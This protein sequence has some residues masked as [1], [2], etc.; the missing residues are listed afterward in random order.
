MM[1]TLNLCLVGVLMLT[2][3]LQAEEKWEEITLATDCEAYVEEV[4]PA[5]EKHAVVRE[6]LLRLCRETKLQLLAQHFDARW[7]WRVT[8]RNKVFWRFSWKVEM[9]NDL[10]EAI[11]LEI[12]GRL[13]DR[14]A[15]ALAKFSLGP[16]VL[17]PGEKAR[18]S[19]FLLLEQEKAETIR[20]ARAT[21]IWKVEGVEIFREK[22]RIPISP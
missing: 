7:S 17:E 20:G 10:P 14:E 5:K 12:D 15:Y 21:F 13:V 3:P 1:R 22:K 19:D 4:S 6:I 2:L 16:F 18:A 8:E 11:A 9:T